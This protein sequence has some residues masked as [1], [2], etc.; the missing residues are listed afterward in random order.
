MSSYPNS[1][2]VW[3]RTTSEAGRPTPIFRPCRDFSTAQPFDL[4]SNFSWSNPISGGG[5]NFGG[6]FHQLAPN[7]VGEPFPIHGNGFSSAWTVESQTV[8]AVE[9]TLGSCGPG[10]F[11]YSAR[12]AYG[13]LGAP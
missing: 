8:S 7:I 6:K 9:L 3:P 1:A 11:R 10:P 2:Q 12:T 13:L 4:A 5:F